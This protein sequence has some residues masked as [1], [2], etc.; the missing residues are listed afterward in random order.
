MALA[1]ARPHEY[2]LINSPLAMKSDGIDQWNQM[3]TYCDGIC[4]LIETNLSLVQST[5]KSSH[6]IIWIDGSKSIASEK[7]HSFFPHLFVDS[8]PK[9]N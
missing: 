9:S 6:R 8:K 5:L 4:F 3:Y 2:S 7:K 1:Q